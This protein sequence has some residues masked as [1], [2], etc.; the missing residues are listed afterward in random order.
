[1]TRQPPLTVV[2]EARE[3]DLL[4]GGFNV[5]VARKSSQGSAGKL[6]WSQ[7]RSRRSRYG[8]FGG[9]FDGRDATR[10]AASPRDA[11]GEAW[12]EELRPSTEQER[13]PSDWDAEVVSF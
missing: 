10:S 7:V 3:E 1:M 2:P 8:R 6:E 5:Q 13:T 9:G 12:R 11:Y 4:R